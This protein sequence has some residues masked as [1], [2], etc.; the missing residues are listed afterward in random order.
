MRNFDRLG[1]VI[2][3]LD[4]SLAGWLGS[5]LPDVA[6]SF[7]APGSSRGQSEQATATASL[8]VVLLSVREDA[9]ASFSGWGELRADDGLLLGR[10]P[11]TRRY[12]FSYLLVAEAGDALL[13]HDVLGRVLAAAALYEVVPP[14]HLAGS[15]DGVG[16][17]VLVRCAPATGTADPQHLWGSWATSPR[18]CLELSVLAPLPLASLLEV[19]QPPRHIDLGA[20][21][22]PAAAGDEGA[23]M[24]ARPRPTSR[25]QEG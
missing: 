5:L 18:A 23:A 1:L 12:R 15:L 16:P 7:E 2:R 13:E 21:K 22:V 25:I 3:D 11:P 8:S 10:L 14:E 9:D 4:A 24:S 17:E 19:P 6:I 20:A